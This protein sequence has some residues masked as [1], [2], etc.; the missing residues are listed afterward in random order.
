M[1]SIASI[2]KQ[3]EVVCRLDSTARQ[4]RRM[5]APINPSPPLD[6]MMD[7]ARK[8]TLEQCCIPWL[9]VQ[10]CRPRSHGLVR[11]IVASRD[12]VRINARPGTDLK[13]GN[14]TSEERVNDMVRQRVPRTH[15]VAQTV[16]ED[17]LVGVFEPALG[18]KDVRIAIQG[19]I[20]RMKCQ[21]DILALGISS[22]LPLLHA[23]VLSTT[24][25]PS[26]ITL[27]LYAI[28]CTAI[29]GNA[30]RDGV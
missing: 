5:T 3:V 19:R 9:K 4:L 6:L 17:G 12:G 13:R 11:W 10:T 7:I 2:I 20:F 27:S 29:L 8:H 30:S 26:G 28:G 1:G 24:V 15:S 25:L 22:T 14:E 23:N 16:A 21:F 18:P